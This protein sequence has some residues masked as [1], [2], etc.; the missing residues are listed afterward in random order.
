M[1]TWG[2]RTK[3]HGTYEGARRLGGRVHE[4]VEEHAE[5]VEVGPCCRR[6]RTTRACFREPSRPPALRQQRA[7]L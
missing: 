5:Q 2:K 3:K 1:R 4:G 6:S 7:M